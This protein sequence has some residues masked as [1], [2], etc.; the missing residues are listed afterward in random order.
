MGDGWDQV[1]QLSL[2][3]LR[4]GEGMMLIERV[5]GGKALPGEVMNQIVAKADG[6]LD[7]TSPAGTLELAALAAHPVRRALGEHA[8][9]RPAQPQALP[10]KVV[11][12]RRPEVILPLLP[13][14]LGEAPRRGLCPPG[15]RA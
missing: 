12:A 9:H 6:V 7:F 11:G 5:L 1:T 2:V 13:R 14:P 15:S 8:E 4:R 10:R 3:R